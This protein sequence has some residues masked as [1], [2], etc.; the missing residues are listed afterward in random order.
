MGGRLEL[1]ANTYRVLVHPTSTERALIGSGPAARGQRRQRW[2]RS[3]VH[4]KK[5]IPYRIDRRLP[6]L[7]GSE[8]WCCHLVWAAL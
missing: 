5:R 8:L 2:T 6:G 4:G 3:M 1:G 7:A